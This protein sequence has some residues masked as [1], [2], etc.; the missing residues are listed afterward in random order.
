MNQGTT[1]TPSYK[2]GTGLAISYNVKK[3]SHLVRNSFL[4]LLVFFL[5]FTPFRTNLLLIGIDRTPEGS[6]A[7]RSDTM[8]LATLPPVLPQVRLLSIPRDLWVNIPGYGENRINTAHYF[9]ELDAPGTGMRAAANVVESNF[10]VNVP[11]VIR[12]KFDG[13]VKIIDAMG[14]VTVDLPEPMS[15]LEA[16]KNYL[17]G[18]AA[19]RFV[20]DRASSDDFFRQKRGQLFL[21]AAIKGVLNPVKW[22][23]LPMILAAVAQSIDTNIPFWIWPRILYGATF[24]AI[25]GFDSNTISR[26]MVT[27][28]TTDQGA[29]VLLPNWDLIN[30]LIQQV[31]R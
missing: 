25:K 27:S 1:Q 16:G 7:G 21:S 9:A 8:I 22:P 14:G 18:T 20:R 23:R 24:S 30:P 28:W 31:L 2:P 13:F 11:Y 17:D 26:E 5:F 4:I 15:G 12:L 10:G 6:A 19:L 29:Q 3:K